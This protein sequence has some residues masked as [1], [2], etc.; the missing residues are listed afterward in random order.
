MSN[1]KCEVRRISG[2]YTTYAPKGTT[3]GV[4]GREYRANNHSGG[5]TIYIGKCAHRESKLSK[6]SLGDPVPNARIPRPV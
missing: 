4:L 5:C 3:Y 6:G 1:A 2:R